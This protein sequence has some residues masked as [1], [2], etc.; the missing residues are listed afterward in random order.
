MNDRIKSLFKQEQPDHTRLRILFYISLL[1][2]FYKNNRLSSKRGVLKSVLG[3]CS[4]V[5]VD[6]LLERYTEEQLTSSKQDARKRYVSL[7]PV[8]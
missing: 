6:G 7:F 5:L 4:N 2:A 8:L 3:N 1:M